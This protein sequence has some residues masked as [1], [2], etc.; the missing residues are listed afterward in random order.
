MCSDGLNYIDTYV[1]NLK[2]TILFIRNSGSR[3]QNFKQICSSLGLQI[4]SLPQDIRIHWNSTYNM[5]RKV[6]PY[7]KAISMFIFMELPD[8]DISEEWKVCDEIC[9]FLKELKE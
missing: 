3:R 1:H 4:K 6:I 9:E 5:L 7:K 2:S 8:Q